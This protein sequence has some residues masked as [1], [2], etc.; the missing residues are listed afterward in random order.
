MHLG[1]KVSQQHCGL[2]GEK[3]Y[4]QVKGDDLSSLLCTGDDVYGVLRPVLGSLVWER[5]GDNGESPHVERPTVMIKGLEH[6][7]SEKKL[8]ELGLFSLENRR[9]GSVEGTPK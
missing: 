6:L 9:L 4:Q 8:R 5:H 3:H 1:S 7:S 2:H